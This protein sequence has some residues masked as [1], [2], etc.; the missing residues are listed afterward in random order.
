V[1]LLWG[2][3]SNVILLND[4]NEEAKKFLLR[5]GRSSVFFFF[6]FLGFRV[7]YSSLPAYMMIH[8]VFWCLLSGCHHSSGVFRRIVGKKG[9]VTATTVTVQQ[10]TLA[11]VLLRCVLRT[12]TLRV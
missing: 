7:V 4:E 12:V 5:G 1:T 9:T 8:A 6:A 3:Y 11:V 10:Y 2:S